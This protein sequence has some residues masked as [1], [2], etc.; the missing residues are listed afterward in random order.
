[1]RF[2]ATT[3]LV[4]ISFLSVI[5]EFAASAAF[6]CIYYFDNQSNFGDL[7]DPAANF[8]ETKTHINYW[9]Y[10]RRK[11]KHNSSCQRNNIMSTE[12]SMIPSI[13]IKCLQ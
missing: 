3:D 11:K 8:Y 12:K 9:T 6:E 4:I 5:V 1:M 10:R 2:F 13:G 7:A